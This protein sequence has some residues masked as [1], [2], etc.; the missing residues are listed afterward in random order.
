MTCAEFIALVSVLLATLLPWEL[1]GGEVLS[2]RSLDQIGHVT[3][4][5]GM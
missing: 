3:R 4:F 1:R 2:P 5:R